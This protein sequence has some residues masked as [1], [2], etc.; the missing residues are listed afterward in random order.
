MYWDE[1]YDVLWR[2]FRERRP[3]AR[4]EHECCEHKEP[5][6]AVGER[7]LYVAGVWRRSDDYTYVTGFKQCLSCEEDWNTVL[8]IFREN[9]EDE[10]CIVYGKL[11][12]AVWD[13]YEEEYIKGD[14]PLIQKWYPE[15]YRDFIKQERMLSDEEVTWQ[16]IKEAAVNSGLQ[17]ALPGL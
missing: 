2:S 5:K 17:P 9:G 16:E 13:A 14:H 10:A 8:E 4:K 7:Y 6:I 11:S 12:S 1:A 3:T 15:V